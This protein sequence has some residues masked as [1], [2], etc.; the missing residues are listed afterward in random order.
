MALNPFFLQGSSS[1]QRLVQSLINE[2]LKM[3]GVEVTYIPRKLINV[4]NIF[5]EVESSKFDDNYSIEAYVNTYE[6][7][8]GGGD[9][10]T[11]FG[12]SLK[13]EVTLTISKERFEDFIS[14]F[15]AAEPDSE[16]PLSTRPREG[17]LI[18]FP[19]GQRLFEVKFVEHEDPFYQL[20]KNYVYQ[21]KCELFEYEDEVI[22]T[23]IDDID[24]QIEDEGYITTLK[25]IG[26]GVTATAS[27]VINT[28]YI[29]QVFLNNDGSGFTSPPVITFEDPLDSTGTT[30]T[31]VGILTTVGGITSL[32]EIVLTNAGAGYTTIP[33]ILIQG[34]GGT[35]AA[36]T[37]SINPAIVG[38][39]STGVVS[40]TVDTAGSGYPIAPTV[41]IARPDAGATATATVGASGTITEFTITSGGEA[42]VAAPTVTISQPN[43]SGSIS[44]FRLN[45]AGIKT[46]NVYSQIPGHSS[47]NSTGVGGFSGSHGQDYEVGDIVTFVGN[48]GGVSA[49]GTE[50]RIRIDSVNSDGQVLGF[51][52]LYGGY[53]YEVSVSSSAG[54]YEAENI[55]GSMNGDGL[56]LRVEL[57]ESVVG[58]TATGTAV[59]GAAGSISSI[60]LTNAGGGYTKSPDAN[61]PT[62][63]VS[64]ANQFKNPGVVQA[65][66]VA[67]VNTSDQVSSIR[68]TDPGSGYVSVPVV[69]ISDPTTIVGIGTYQFNEIIRGSTSGAE[70]RVKSWDDMTNTLKVS[71]V[72]G[73]FREGENIVGTASSAVY[74]MSSYN[75]DDTYDKYTENDEIESEADDILDFT[76]SNPFGVF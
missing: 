42:Y 24:R 55:S 46:D 62:V 15:L 14:P 73:T 49:A 44:S 32:K 20:G 72:T 41:T 43:R 9:I 31:A 53:D 66:A 70:A 58:T 59:V 4:D 37:C 54:L 69:T 74:S 27:A 60:T 61:A 67:T 39:G 13:D 23:S 26:I 64:N 1:E 56:R 65:T 45:T 34:G 5:T 21:L 38:V 8:A 36:A 11:K 30:A 22:D 52:Q 12:M 10:L 57:V 18:Y 33:N 35:G 29:R 47:L 48:N 40:L 2:Q 75:A 28:G 50:S 19:L 17:D 51:T 76:E 3:Y 71:Y 25:L 68:I 7:Y 6:G 63:T 16:V